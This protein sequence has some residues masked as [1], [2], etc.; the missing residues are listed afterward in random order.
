MLL[1]LVRERATVRVA[2]DQAIRAD[3]GR[4]FQHPET[5]LGIA[6][7]A[8]EEVLGV[9]EHLE[10]AA[11]Q[12]LD[13]V[14]DHGDALV[15]RRAQRF[16]HVVVPALADDADGRGVRLDEV[17]QRVVR[18]DLALDPAGHAE[19]HELA[20]LELELG[21]CALEELVVLRVRARPAGFD[22]VDAEPVELLGDAQLVVDRE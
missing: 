14:R 7:V 10:P 17:A 8:V 18:V 13:R 3:L 22:V 5:E 15:E 21:R 6:L 4:A 9:E 11:L 16:E 12:V 1:D 19:R 20:R 2:E